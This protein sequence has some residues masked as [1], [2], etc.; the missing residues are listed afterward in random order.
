MKYQ[1]HF[2][3][4]FYFDDDVNVDK[5]EE[6]FKIKAYKKTFLK[7]SK[8]SEKAAKIWYRTQKMTDENIGEKLEEFFVSIYDNFKDLKRILLNNHGVGSLDLIF[9]EMFERPASVALTGKTI[10]ILNEFGLAFDMDSNCG[11]I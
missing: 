3:L 4:H 6:F 9:D 7:D 1:Y 10:K 5:V 2:S 11:F 8:G